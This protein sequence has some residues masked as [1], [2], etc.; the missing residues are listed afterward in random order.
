M[1]PSDSQ[2]NGPAVSA[3]NVI[4]VSFDSD[5]DAYSALTGLKEL[6]AQSRVS[7]DAAAVVVRGD[8]GTLAVK[9]GVGFDPY[10]G[11]ASG[12][13]LGLLIGILGGPLG[14]LSEERTGSWSAPCSTSSR[15]RTPRQS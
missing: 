12:G 13:V 7:V 14:V 1:T 15:P 6:D 9:D 3:D 8:D 2:G 5:N 4:S 11:A 10:D